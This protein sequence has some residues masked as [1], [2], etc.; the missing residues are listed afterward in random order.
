MRTICLLFLT[1]YSFLAIGQE[2]VKP[3]PNLT[4]KV[5]VKT[6]QK[7][8]EKIFVTYYNYAT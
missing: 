2:T 1:I 8:V 4:L 3:T 7:P 6:I 5:D